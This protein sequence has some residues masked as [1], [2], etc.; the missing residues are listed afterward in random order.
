MSRLPGRPALAG[1]PAATRAPGLRTR[2]VG[3]GTGA[4][5]GTRPRGDT[6]R[7]HGCRRQRGRVR[8]GRRVVEVPVGA[9]RVPV[10]RAAAGATGPATARPAGGRGRGGGACRPLQDPAPSQEGPRGE[11]TRRLIVDT[12][13][14]LFREQGYDRTTMR[15]I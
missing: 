13:V 5:P 7:R 3:G 10:A 4:V 1:E 15:A 12:A 11:Q 6:P 2:R 9:V 8:R 14:R